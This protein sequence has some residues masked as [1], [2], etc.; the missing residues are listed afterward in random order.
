M[1]NKTF[2]Q[3]GILIL[4][5]VRSENAKKSLKMLFFDRI[6]CFLITEDEALEQ[7]QRAS[8][9]KWREIVKN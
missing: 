2:G 1:Q 8:K 9:G 5:I 4:S 3:R 6:L 7:F